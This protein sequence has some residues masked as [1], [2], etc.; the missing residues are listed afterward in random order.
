[1]SA[2]ESC[3]DFLRY[4]TLDACVTEANRRKPTEKHNEIYKCEGRRE[5]K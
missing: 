2:G 3:T 5:K 4:K 1:M